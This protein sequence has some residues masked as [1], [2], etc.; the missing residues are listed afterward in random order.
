NLFN[1]LVDLKNGG[2]TIK[3]ALMDN[4]HTFDPD[5][6]TFADVSAN[7][8][9]SSGT[10]YTSG[11][12]TLANQAVTQDDANDLA[13]YDA[14]DVQWTTVTFTAYHA[15]IYDDTWAGDDLIG[16]IDFGGAKAV[17]GG[18]FTIAWN[19]NGII[20]LT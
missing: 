5:D 1:K 10:G 13:K 8:L 7:E 16:S 17:T 15:V 9:L 18:T 3:V 12:E 4:V 14:D 19:S 11:G 6:N 2:D 20:K